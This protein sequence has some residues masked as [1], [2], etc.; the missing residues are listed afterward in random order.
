MRNPLGLVLSMHETRDNYPAIRKEVVT[1]NQQFSNSEISSLRSVLLNDWLD[2]EY[3]AEMLE[4]FLTGR[5]YGISRESALE[6]AVNVRCEGFTVAAIRQ[7]LEH[8]ALVM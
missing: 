5:G 8:F 3:T 7:E 4:M 1:V 2:S 6:A